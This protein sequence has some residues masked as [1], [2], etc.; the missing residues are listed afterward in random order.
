MDAV[1]TTGS[2]SLICCGMLPG[3]PHPTLIILL[4]CPITLTLTLSY[5]NPALTLT[6]WFLLLTLTLLWSPFLIVRSGFT[7]VLP[8][9]MVP[10]MKHFNLDVLHKIACLVTVQPHKVDVTFKS[11]EF[12]DLSRL[13]DIAVSRNVPLPVDREHLSV[14]MELLVSRVY[15][16]IWSRPKNPFF[17]YAFGVVS[18]HMGDSLQYTAVHKRG[19]LIDVRW[20]MID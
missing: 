17:L 14:E 12:F 13:I 15:L 19:K 18:K 8:G 20:S 7:A 9:Y 1:A 5:L 3:N 4:I 11:V 16:S 6:L 10:I 2:P